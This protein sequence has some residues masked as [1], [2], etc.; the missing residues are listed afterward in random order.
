MRDPVRGGRGD[1]DPLLGPRS[2]RDLFLPVRALPLLRRPRRPRGA[3]GTGRPPRRTHALRSEL[4][5]V[6][7]GQSVS[8]PRRVRSRRDQVPQAGDVRVEG[9]PGRR[10]TVRPRRPPVGG[11]LLH[12][13]E[14][15]R[16][17]PHHVRGGFHRVSAELRLRA[18]G[19]VRRRAQ[20]LRREEF[21][22]GMDGQ[23][24]VPRRVRRRIALREERSAPRRGYDPGH[25][26]QGGRASGLD[27]RVPVGAPLGPYAAGGQ[28]RSA[29]HS[30][31][32]PAVRDGCG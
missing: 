26:E 13:G 6:Q 11:V 14:E 29:L 24:R 18:A 12:R 28:H 15:A 17:V 31:S 10:G 25:D 21:G 16:T 5:R 32:Q 22:P 9:S 1:R 3:V 4:P 20:E 30:R 23:A 27:R 19:R 8:R 2:R 7:P